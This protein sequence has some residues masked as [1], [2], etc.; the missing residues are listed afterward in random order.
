MERLTYS[1]QRFFENSATPAE[2]EELYQLLKTID[3]E[4]SEFFRPLEE[5]LKNEVHPT[6]EE[7]QRLNAIFNKLEQKIQTRK[8]GKVIELP[9]ILRIA[10]SILIVM[11]A[12]YGVYQFTSTNSVTE[13]IAQTAD[14]KPGT[15]KAILTLANG[16][17]VK[18][19]GTGT[20]IPAQGNA[21][22]QN[23]AGSISYVAQANT[24]DVVYNTVT[25]ERAGQYK[26]TLADGS[27]VWLNAESSLTFPASFSGNERK[28]KVVGEAYFEIAHN[29]AMPFRVELPTGAEVEVLGTHF[30]VM[31]YRDEDA[32]KTTLLEGSVR[33]TS[34]AESAL[35]APNQQAQ[36]SNTGALSVIKNYDVNQAVAWKDGAFVF[37]DTQLDEI[38]R[39]VSRWYDVE[40]SYADDVRGL[41][42]G[43]KIS[44][45]EN[46][47]KVLAL[48]ELTGEVKF[49]I[50]GKKIIVKS[51]KK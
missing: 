51:I 48:L 39:Q 13:Q 14:V 33:I 17:T 12:M 32:I 26:L 25:T 4:T 2:R 1:R 15:D 5:E 49:E 36:I 45:K 29:K 8:E 44:R 6:S 20:A 24:N 34:G 18:L 40:V 31:A 50:Q 43:G 7:Q 16:E 38:M 41:Q 22:I 21:Q 47:S 30:N 35:L 3:P 27:R 9:R 19:N 23:D 46:A 37:N 28:V 11:L 42:F 10:A